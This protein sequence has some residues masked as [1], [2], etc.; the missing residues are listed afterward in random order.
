MIGRRDAG[1]AT[2]FLR[3]VEKRLANRIQL[4]TG[5]HKMY[6]NAEP[7]ASPSWMLTTGRFSKSRATI[8]KGKSGTTPHSVGASKRRRYLAIRTRASLARATLNGRT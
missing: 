4:S 2:E 5:G 1:F 8:L 3:D 6:L 7:D